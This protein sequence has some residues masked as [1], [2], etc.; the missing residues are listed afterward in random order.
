MEH[1][2]VHAKVLEFK[3]EICYGGSPEG[4]SVSDHLYLRVS[5]PPPGTPRDFMVGPAYEDC[6]HYSFDA[7]N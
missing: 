3:F 1:N 2:V 5:T 6:D 4:T 7:I